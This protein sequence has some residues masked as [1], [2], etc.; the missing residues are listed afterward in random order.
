MEFNSARTIGNLIL[1]LVL[2]LVAP[3]IVG[4]QYLEW[5]DSSH[6]FFAISG[7]T[8][9]IA[10]SDW[11]LNDWSIGFGPNFFVLIPRVLFVIAL[12][13]FNRNRASKDHV[14]IF[15]LLLIGIEIVI[16]LYLMMIDAI[17]GTPPGVLIIL[18]EPDVDIRLFLPTPLLFLV[19]MYQVRT[20]QSGDA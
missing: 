9:G 10:Y 8:W 11:Y 19:G 17:F 15:G 6:L 4:F 16:C 20:T 2:A 12:V 14:R 18:P 5:R 13:G 1:L 7:S 3:A